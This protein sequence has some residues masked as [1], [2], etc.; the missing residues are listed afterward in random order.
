MKRKLKMGFWNKLRDED[1]E[2]YNE[3]QEVETNDTN[4]SSID[5]TQPI[6]I[7]PVEVSS[8]SLL[9]NLTIKGTGLKIETKES[10]Y[11]L[12]CTIEGDV[13]TKQNITLDGGTVKGSISGNAVVLQN[14][15]T[16]EGNIKKS[17]IVN[18]EN[19]KVTGEIIADE[20]IVNSHVNGSIK[21]KMV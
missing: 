16:I 8:E 9:S 4:V 6:N 18:V 5:T 10:L 1:F 13:S 14:E 7:S 11:L 17:G 2:D 12:N 15:A 3:E 21:A 20:V 19:G